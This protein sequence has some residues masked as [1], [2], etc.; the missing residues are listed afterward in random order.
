MVVL[1]KNNGEFQDYIERLKGD[2]LGKHEDVD[3]ELLDEEIR[4]KLEKKRQKLEAA[5]HSEKGR[6]KL[7]REFCRMEAKRVQLEIDGKTEESK[8]LQKKIQLKRALYKQ[9][10]GTK[11]D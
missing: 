8:T 6:D 2:Y 4:K 11:K 10:F 7:K 3:E 9:K 1:P 5:S